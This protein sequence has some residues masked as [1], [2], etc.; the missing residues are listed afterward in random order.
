M[1]GRALLWHVVSAA[2][3][4]FIDAVTAF[5]PM[6]TVHL[7]VVHVHLDRSHVHVGLNVV[8]RSSPC[9]NHR[10]V[11]SDIRRLAW[12]A[13][14]TVGPHQLCQAAHSLMPLLDANPAMVGWWRSG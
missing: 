4:P 11:R 2:A 8:V 1:C 6:Y 3:W 7:V 14:M 9:M 5:L 10:P 13:G 12:S